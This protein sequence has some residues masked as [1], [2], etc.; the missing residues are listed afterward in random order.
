MR[1]FLPLATV[2]LLTLAS[3]PAKPF[4]SF[5]AEDQA[6]LKAGEVVAWTDKVDKKHFV[7]VAVVLDHPL[8][9]VWSLIDDKEAAPTFIATLRSAKL[10]SREANV[11]VIAQETETL[12]A[13]RTA[14]YVVEHTSTYP[15][16]VAFRRLRGDFR[17][18]EG[19]WFF[20]PIDEGAKKKTLLVYDLHVDAG[21]LIP[22]SL[23]ANSQMKSLPIVMTSIREKLATQVWPPVAQPAGTAPAKTPSLA[24]LPKSLP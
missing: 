16:L 2:W 15:Q 8:D 23:I 17:H 4:L 7:H 22:Q 21:L 11:C 20:D 5:S 14:K 6:R 10:L 19:N 1:T 13:G 9:Q 18:I 3:L 12:G 24:G